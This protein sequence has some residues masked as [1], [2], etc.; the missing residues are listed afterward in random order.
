[1][2]VEVAELDAID[3]GSGNVFVYLRHERVAGPCEVCLR[4][5]L[6]GHKDTVEILQQLNR[7]YP[8]AA[9]PVEEGVQRFLGE[10]NAALVGAAVD[11]VEAGDAPKLGALL[12]QFQARAQAEA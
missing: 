7:A 10:R 8:V 11:A 4:E 6:S 3:V 2:T 1:M 5:R 9:T 12:D